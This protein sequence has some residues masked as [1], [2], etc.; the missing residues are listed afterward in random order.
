MTVSS[1][2]ELGRSQAELALKQFLSNGNYLPEIL[3]DFHDQKDIFK[4]MHHLSGW[5]DREG[6]ARDISWTEGQIYVIDL[7]LHFMARHGYTLQRS[8]AKQQF[9]S[10]EDKRARFER[11]EMESLKKLLESRRSAGKPGDMRAV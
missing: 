6:W 8:R 11:E 2:E 3:K 9:H 7:F 5:N 1:D 4:L 10:L